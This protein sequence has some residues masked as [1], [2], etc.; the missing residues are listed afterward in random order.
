M[1]NH[2]WAVWMTAEGI[3][4]FLPW[5]VERYVAQWGSVPLLARN[6]IPTSLVWIRSYLDFFRETLVVEPYIFQFW[7]V[8]LVYHVSKLHRSLCNLQKLEGGGWVGGRDPRAFPWLICSLFWFLT[9]SSYWQGAFSSNCAF[10]QFLVI[11]IEGET[12]LL[13]EGS[14]QPVICKK[15]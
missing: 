4:S 1:E 14:L 3:A 2:C 13:N 10:S 7:E 5:L 9:G 8:E 15:S 11:S 6:K 12:S